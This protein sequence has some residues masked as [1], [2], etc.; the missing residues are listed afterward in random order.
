M[1]INIMDYLS[2]KEIGECIKEELKK[3]ISN[4]INKVGVDTFISNISYINV[5]KKIDE[6]IPDFEIQIKEKVKNIIENLSDYCVFKEKSVF[7]K[8]SL[9]QKLLNNAVE[10]N[11]NILNE[12]GSLEVETPR[13]DAVAGGAAASPFI[14]HHNTLN[15]DMY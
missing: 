12:K 15:L 10:E 3:Q 1:E 8:E 9:G 14:T 7:E 4:Y 6:E 2:E 11:K 13:L 5:F